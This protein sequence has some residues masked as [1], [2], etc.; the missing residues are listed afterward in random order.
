MGTQEWAHITFGSKMHTHQQ[1]ECQEL[2]TKLPKGESD[3]RAFV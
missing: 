3:F 2:P 1:A